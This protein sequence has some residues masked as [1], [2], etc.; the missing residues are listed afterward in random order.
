MSNAEETSGPR[1]LAS[2]RGHA[3]SMARTKKQGEDDENI[4]RVFQSTMLRRARLG[5]AGEGRPLGRALYATSVSS[6]A[7][8][9]IAPIG[10]R[11]PVLAPHKE[12]MGKEMRHNPQ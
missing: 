4:F 10:G 1:A 8:L 7:V 11:K 5:R 12:D 2:L 9:V 3:V 6:P